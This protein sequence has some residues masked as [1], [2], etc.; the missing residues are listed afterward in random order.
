MK[1]VLLD[2][3]L[4]RQLKRYFS[5][6]FEVTSVPDLGW[7]TKKNGELLTAMDESG[8]DYLLTSD[9]NLRFQQNLEK[10]R[11]KVIVLFTFD[12]RLKNLISK[13]GEIETKIKEADNFDKVIEV[14]IRG[15]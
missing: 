6:D 4:P 15:K 14:D 11:A 5:T 13:V 10:F 7:Q 3:N 1:K 12:N 2:E 9:K 8:I